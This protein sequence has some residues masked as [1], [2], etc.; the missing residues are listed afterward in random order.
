MK[1][2]RVLSQLADAGRNQYFHAIH[3]LSHGASDTITLGTDVLTAD[4]LSAW[5]SQLSAIGASLSDSG[6]ILLTTSP[7]G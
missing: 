2:A 6:E 4:N 1:T 5:S 3:I 7:P